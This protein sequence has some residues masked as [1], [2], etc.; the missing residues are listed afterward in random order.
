[1]MRGVQTFRVIVVTAILESG[2]LMAQ[3]IPAD[4]LEDSHFREEFG[5]NEVTTPS[6]R[7]IFGQLAGWGKISWSR[8]GRAIPVDQPSER[9]RLALSLGGLIAEGFF[10]TQAEDVKRLEDLGNAIVRRASALGTGAALVSHVNA[11]MEYSQR[12]D[13]TGLREEL[14]KAQQRVQ[15]ELVRLRDVEAV[16]LISLGGWLRAVEVV[17]AVASDPYS[18][19]K[20][21]TLRRADVVTYYIE[22]LETLR[23]ETQQ[24]DYIIRLRRG[25]EKLRTLI[26]G[27]ATIS[28]ERLHEIRGVVAEMAK[29]AFE[30]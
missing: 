11:L 1:M 26:G 21:Q 25:L 8:Y 20:A 7:K 19:E 29:C 24:L 23:P 5:V 6:I 27:D 15:L 12:G 28:E 13:W 22:E 3:D 2:R 10:V 14:A 16:H 30:G 4:L 18:P 9:P 17:C